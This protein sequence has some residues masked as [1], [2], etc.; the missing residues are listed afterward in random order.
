MVSLAKRILSKYLVSSWL[1]KWDIDILGKYLGSSELVAL[2]RLVA[3]RRWEFHAVPSLRK[4]GI[5]IELKGN[6]VKDKHLRSL[7]RLRTV[8]VINLDGCQITDLGLAELAG[9][10]SLECLVLSRTRVTD[11]GLMH[12]SDLPN[13]K[14]LDVDGTSISNSGLRAAGL[15]ERRFS[16]SPIEREAAEERAAVPDSVATSADIVQM[17]RRLA[18]MRPDVC[19]PDLAISLNNLGWGSDS[20]QAVAA[21]RAAVAINRRLVAHSEA[22]RPELYNSLS[23]LGVTLEKR[24]RY[25]EALE[26]SG[27]AIEVFRQIPGTQASTDVAL[28]LQRLSRLYVQANR[29]E[30]AVQAIR[31]S[32]DLF[33]QR[34]AAL[35]NAL[36]LHS[37]FVSSLNDL[38]TILHQLDRK[39]EAM[40]AI[41]EAV[42]MSR[43][44][45]RKGADSK[46]L[47]ASLNNLQ[48]LLTDLDQ[49]EQA[50]LAKQEAQDLAAQKS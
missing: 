29:H 17:N 2:S 19:L 39:Q 45:F 25:D 1:G 28:N 49:H 26:A 46:D 16:L 23:N 47:I 18:A 36:M 11:A 44:L 14:T 10:G 30:Q 48:R 24:G 50:K 9:M 43:Q 32:V 21:L 40:E 13:L 34:V 37:W 15:L 5:T 31:E 27:E 41:T 22:F 8:H 4:Q 12:L 35:P 3:S 42:D 38:G 20:E 33:R 7:C 6:A